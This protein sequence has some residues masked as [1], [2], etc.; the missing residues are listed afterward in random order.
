MPTRIVAISG[1][2]G[3]GKSTTLTA[4]AGMGYKVDDFKVSREM[5]K[6]FGAELQDLIKTK[7]GV[8]EFQRAILNAKMAREEELLASDYDGIILTERSFADISSYANIWIDDLIANAQ[9]DLEEGSNFKMTFGDICSD[10]QQVYSALLMLPYMEHVGWVSD[11]QRAT[12]DKIAAFDVQ[13]ETF[14]NLLQPSNVPVFNITAQ[15][16][17]DR[18][19]EIN[20]FLRTL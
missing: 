2:Q 18:A 12:K 15:T 8:I 4:L 13:M 6:K 5:Q 17:N 9:I 1:T 16:I 3:A 7:N 20:N 19:V 14:I 10:Y 11:P